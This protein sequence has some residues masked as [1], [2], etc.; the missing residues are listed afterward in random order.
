MRISIDWLK[1]FVDVPSS[2][3]KIADMLTMLGLEA[4]QGLDTAN[5]SDIIIA[6]I[7]IMRLFIVI[8][9]NT[10]KLYTFIKRMLFY[11]YSIL[12]N[13]YS[14]LVNKNVIINIICG[15]STRVIQN[16]LKPE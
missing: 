14:L 15:V 4:E 2:T 8:Q 7:A 3:E 16:V 1:E 13:I 10:S 5:L 11:Q 9:N 12:R 6:Y